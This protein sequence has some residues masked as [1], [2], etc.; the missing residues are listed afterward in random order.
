MKANA[1][2]V[3]PTSN[4]RARVQATSSASAARPD[5]AITPRTSFVR[6]AVASPAADRVADG[7]IPVP[8]Q[9]I[10]AAARFHDT[11]TSVERPIPRP[12]RSRNTQARAPITAPPVL[13]A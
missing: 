10:A 3:G 9:T 2:A 7:A 13:A 4:T 1:K 8:R 11:A 12:G 6:A 5:S